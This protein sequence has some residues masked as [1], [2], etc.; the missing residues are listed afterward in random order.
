MLKLFGYDGLSEITGVPPKTLKNWY[1]KDPGK[2]PPA[3]IIPGARGPRWTEDVVK[4]WIKDHLQTPQEI[5][6]VQS[7]RR[8]VKK[9]GKDTSASK[10]GKPRGRPRLPPVSDYSEL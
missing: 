1:S 8:H 7:L 6:K 5:K 9:S 10:T 2:L 4:T 3:V